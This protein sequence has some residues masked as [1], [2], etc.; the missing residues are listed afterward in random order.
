M[1]ITL[2]VLI[3]VNVEAKDKLKYNKTDCELFWTSVKA[4]TCSEILEDIYEVYFRGDGVILKHG[5]GWS[6]VWA[7]ALSEDEYPEVVLL[8]YGMSWLRGRLHEAKRYALSKCNDQLDKLK[9]EVADLNKTK[10]KCEIVVENNTIINPKFK[11]L[12]SQATGNDSFII[13]EH[14]M[15]GGWRLDEGRFIRNEMTAQVSTFSEYSSDVQQLTERIMDQMLGVSVTNLSDKQ[16]C[17]TAIDRMTE[18]VVPWRWGNGKFSGEARSRGLSLLDCQQ[19]IGGNTQNEMTAQADTTDIYN[20][21]DVELCLGPNEPLSIFDFD[22]ATYVTGLNDPFLTQKPQTAYAYA[23]TKRGINFQKCQKLIVDFREQM[24]ISEPAT[25]QTVTVSESNSL[26]IND[27][28]YNY[29]L[30]FQGDLRRT[31]KPNFDYNCTMD[32]NYDGGKPDVV[33]D[34]NK[35]CSETPNPH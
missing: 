21:S 5:P 24:L 23:A 13:P 11:Q 30:T 12:I 22:R 10:A 33:T 28:E 32:V 1:F 34:I 25:T 31:K 3:S 6:D 26:K 8:A 29:C 4:G 35:F 14:K 20:L 15:D 17:T 2:S 16:V 19:I 9:S 18:P 27:K 7:M